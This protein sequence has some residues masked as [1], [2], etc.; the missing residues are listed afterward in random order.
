VPTDKLF[1]DGLKKPKAKAGK[2][3]ILLIRTGEKKQGVIGLH[4]AG[5][6]G[7]QSRGLSVRFMGIDNKGVGSYLLSIYC[8]A[9]ILTTDAIGVLED[10]DI[11]NYYEYK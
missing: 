4:Q 8:S 11:G 10:V 5:L 1:V 7:E 2:T 9:A 6:P 3:N